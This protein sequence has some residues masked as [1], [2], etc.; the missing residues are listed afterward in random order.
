MPVA[1]SLTEW[2]LG[3]LEKTGLDPSSRMRVHIVLH[4]FI[5]GMSVNLEEE[6]RAL[7][8]TGIDEEEWMR[9][10]EG[11]FAALGEQFP[12]FGRFLTEVRNDFDFDLEQLFEFGLQR[13]L[14]GVAVMIARAAREGGREPW[15]RR[16]LAVRRVAVDSEA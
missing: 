1:L 6:A 15:P 4:G 11:R 8:E 10:Q 16:P 12:A 7:S 5:Q 13:L 2:V 3:A 14:D 9:T